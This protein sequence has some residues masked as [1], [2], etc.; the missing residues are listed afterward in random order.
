MALRGIE[1]PQGPGAVPKAENATDAKEK[2]LAWWDKRD[3]RR[4]PRQGREKWRRRRRD[5]GG[6]G[7]GQPW[8]APWDRGERRRNPA[9]SA[10]GV[11]D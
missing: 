5:N 6:T 11:L 7:Q 3:R 9:M 8:A 4:N 2:G 1:T 10:L